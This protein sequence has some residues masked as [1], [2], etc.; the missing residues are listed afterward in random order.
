M[1]QVNEELKTRL[2]KIGN[3]ERDQR[4]RRDAVDAV[5]RLHGGRGA[6]TLFVLTE[7]EKVAKWLK[8]GQR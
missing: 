3:E 7:A 2:A 8:T 1:V 6:D 5:V 4:F